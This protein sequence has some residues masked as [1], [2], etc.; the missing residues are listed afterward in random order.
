[1]SEVE[2]LCNRV[3]IIQRGRVIR[4]SSLAELL[5]A[6]IGRYRL[7]PTEPEQAVRV[8]AAEPGVRELREHEGSLLFA[9]DQ[10]TVARLSIALGQAGIGIRALIPESAS[11]EEVFFQ[12]TERDGAAPRA[13]EAQVAP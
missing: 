13:V 5:E 4:E 1:M 8:V 9:A 11:L 2:E 12:L 3:A 7:D 6:A 10:D